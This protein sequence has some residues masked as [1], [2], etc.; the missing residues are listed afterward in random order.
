MMNYT[1]DIDQAQTIKSGERIGG[2]VMLQLKTNQSK[3]HISILSDGLGSGIQANVMATLT[4]RMAAQYITGEFD[5]TRAAKIIMD[6]LPV[7]SRRRIS[8][9]TFSICDIDPSGYTRIIEY[10]NPPFIYLKNDQMITPKREIISLNRQRAF[11][12]E[13]LHYTTFQLDYGDRLIFC[14]DGVTQAGL[15]RK[16]YPLG[17]RYKPLQSFIQQIVQKDPECSSRTLARTIVDKATSLDLLGAKDDISTAVIYCRKPRRTL[18]VTGPPIDPQRDEMMS[19]KVVNFQGKKVV[20]GG[21]TAAIIARFL[22]EEITINLKNRTRKIPPTSNIAGIDLV[23]EGMLTL[24]QV[25]TILE[26]KD[27]QQLAHSHGAAALASFLIN[28]DEIT[29]LIGTCINNAHQDPSI[30]FDM[31]IRRTIIRRI[32]SALEQNYLK[33]VTVELI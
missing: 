22:K 12:E 17:W 10:D 2:D 1:L 23:T 30:P 28:S 9:A 16:Q 4:A 33:E 21:T 15:G 29:F 5:I 6:T 24:N 20:S 3:H 13:E 32:V 19:Q 14:S 31:G 11:K 8:Y 26:Q 7:C 25:A 27:E 18:V